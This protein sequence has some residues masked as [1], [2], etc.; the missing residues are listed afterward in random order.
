MRRNENAA[1]AG[2]TSGT[3]SSVA[4][5]TDS[6]YTDESQQLFGS[7]LDSELA[8]T[9]FH[10]K[11]GDTL[12]RIKISLRSFA[13]QMANHEKPSKDALPL[14]KLARFDDIKTDKGS[15]RHDSNVTQVSGIEC[16]YDAGT[17]PMSEAAGLLKA[18]GIAA[19]LYESPS[20]TATD[21]RWRIML[22][23]SKSLSPEERAALVA[24][25]N[26]VLG[27]VLAGESYTLSQSY[28]FG[29]VQGTAPRKV[30]LVE[31]RYIDQ[32]TDLDAR[33]IGRRGS[34]PQGERDDSSSGAAFR[35][36]MRLQLNG[37][38]I[39]AFEIWAA[40]NPWNDC[41]AN[42]D[43]AVERTWQRAGIE[44][45]KVAL[46][47]RVNGAAYFDDL[48]K[49][50]FTA[51]PFKIR[52]LQAIPRREWL[53]GNSYGRKLLSAIGASG[54]TGKSMLTIAE[55]LS[56]A[57]GIPFLGESLPKGAL[58]VW[59]INSED[60]K[61]EL[62]RR[63]EA[64]IQ[65]HGI[66]E[67]DLGDRLYYTGN[68]TRF[69]VAKQERD[70]MKII[71]PLVDAIKAEIR[72]LG[73]DVLTIDP[74]VST[75]SVSENDND[76][77]NA[78][79]CIWRDIAQECN[80][81]VTLVHH[82]RKLGRSAQGQAQTSHTVDDAR[83]ASALVAATRS[84]RVINKMTEATATKLGLVDHWRYLHVTNGKANY[85]PPI[86]AGKWF[87]LATVDASEH[88]TGVGVIE[89]WELPA[90]ALASVSSI[91]VGKALDALQDGTARVDSRSSDWAG[92]RVAA[93]IGCDDTAKLK[94]LLG[95]WKAAGYL[96]V[97][98]RL[99][100]QRR[101]RDYY[102]V[103]SRPQPYFEEVEE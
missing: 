80:C 79:A 7:P 46:A 24:R 18:A 99:D 40:D 100:D 6:L 3:G 89:A 88:D 58:R 61:E 33:A 83:G 45:G 73:I 101:P 66:T 39:E 9:L 102:V 15:L 64:A 11:R 70:G 8:A 26:G 49:A 38:T 96:E 95:Q 74:F 20:A 29:R 2:T 92:K 62:D 19:L 17:M 65:H 75:H 63:F 10:S 34:D 35:E 68:E 85:S 69:V 16:D 21:Q 32:A 28:F 81:S 48:G 44:A 41:H 76:K 91:E 42:P 30:L 98:K 57:S 55:D 87:K 22:P 4:P 53:Y 84:F 59:H 94:T 54:G 67:A 52:G 1:V 82:M 72:R 50:E 51:T 12:K 43:R 27:G 47:D 78:V 31:G 97:E 13:D 71:T 77:I 90:I 60:D 56:M 5:C 23:C 36:A 103:V 93:A 25:V 14:I 37:Y 86:T